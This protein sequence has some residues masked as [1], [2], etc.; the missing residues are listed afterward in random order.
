MP[1]TPLTSIMTDDADPGRYFE[2][3][4]TAAVRAMRGRSI[5]VRLKLVTDPATACEPQGAAF[6]GLLQPAPPWLTITPVR[7]IPVSLDVAPKVCPNPLN[8]LDNKLIAAIS[9]TDALDV[10]S[11]DVS[12]VR[13]M[14]VPPI[15]AQIKDVSMPPNPYSYQPSACA[16]DGPDGVPDLLLIFD[17]QA[18]VRALDQG[19]DMCGVCEGRVLGLWVSGRMRPEAGGRAFAGQD[20]AVVHWGH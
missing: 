11:I 7:A 9:G 10:R 1:A 14:G 13:M 18:V 4:V 8:V 12:S 5:G 3:D 20:L 2:V 16:D 19:W 15:R 6:D 17:M